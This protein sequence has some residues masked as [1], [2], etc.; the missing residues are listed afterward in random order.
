MARFWTKSPTL[1]DPFNLQKTE[2][3]EQTSGRVLEGGPLSFG[4][5]PGRNFVVDCTAGST[6]LGTLEIP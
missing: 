6:G 2:E 5:G 3:G 4:G 1:A